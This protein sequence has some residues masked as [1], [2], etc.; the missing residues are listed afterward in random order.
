MRI[1]IDGRALQGNRTGIGRY[2]FE[3]CRELDRQLPEA[4]FF[5]Y[6][7]VLIEM[8]VLSERWVLKVEP[9]PWLR[10]IKSVL[11]LKIRCGS[12]C[13]RDEL[14]VFWGGATFMPHLPSTI[15]TVI[16]VYDLNYKIV[17]ET[18]G[19]AHRW[20][21]RLFF[22]N[23]VKNADAVLTISKGTSDRLFKLFGRMADDIVYPAIDSSFS[24]QSEAR[25]QEVLL[26]HSLQRPYLLAVATWEP[27]KNL[28]LLIN[29]FF[30]M[31]RQGELSEHSLVLVGGRGWKDQRLTSLLSGVNSIIPLGYVADNQLAPLYSGADLFIFPSLYEG[32]GMPILEARACRTRILTSN[33]AELHEAG[34][35]DAIYIQPTSIGIQKGILFA[36]SQPKPTYEFEKKYPS[37][38]NSAAILVGVLTNKSPSKTNR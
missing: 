13:R 20:A 9:I 34:G 7:N 1:G 10:K 28:E 15:R 5:V 14:D 30:V 12:L 33:I 35:E 32:F 21:F 8:P 2:V 3:L 25:V 27:R 19:I 22:K 4:K 38:G 11:W 24:L 16:T 31:K 18:M 17:P 23:D 36:L 6:S 37:W 29:T 26:E